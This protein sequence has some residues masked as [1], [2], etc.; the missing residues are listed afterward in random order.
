MRNA[1]LVVGSLLLLANCAPGSDVGGGGSGAGNSNGNGNGPNGSTGTGFGNGSTGAGVMQGCSPDL[2]SVIDASGNIIQT[3]P[4]DQ[5]CAGGTCVPACDAA[6]ASQGNVGCDFVVATPDFLPIIA[7]PCFAVFV[8]NNWD[9]DA[10]VSVSRAGSTF[11]VSAYGRIATNDPNVASWAPVPAT[12]IPPGKV[13]V[14]FLS[15]D[16]N[17]VNGTPLTCPIPPAIN[18]PGGSAVPGSGVGTSWHVTTDVP[19]STYDMLPYGGAA[20]FLPSAE[21]VQPT[22]AWGTNYVAVLP[23]PANFNQG[24]AGGPS[25]GQIVASQDGTTVSVLPSIGLPGAG[26]V[27]GAPA[28]QT[29]TFTLNAGDYVQWEGPEMTGSVFQSDKPISFTGGDGYICYQSQ[30]SSGGGCDSAHQ[31]IPAIR[32]LGSEYVAP[33]YHSRGT[34]VESIPYRLVGAVNGTVLAYDPPIPGAPTTL[35]LGQSVSFETSLPFKISSQDADHPFYVGQI[36]TGEGVPGNAGA[37]GDEEFVN[38]LPPAQWLQK[39]VFFTDPTYTTT[40]LVLVRLK[41]GDVFEDVNVDCVGPV[42]GW[43]PVGDG[44]KYEITDVDLV[45]DGTRNGA[46]ANGP[47][48][49]DSKGAFGLMVWGTAYY[50][51][52]AYPAGGNAASINTVVVPPVPQ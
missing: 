17:S 34:S 6:A 19:V 8:T 24:I 15:Q 52:Y 43:H 5:G 37:I 27:P 46:C 28:G 18:Q 40:N 41:H 12:G 49:A 3:C 11:D 2:K 14:I 51:S 9:K 32:A 38:I 36:M 23:M 16:P 20:S 13:G 33:P 35:A 48:T 50:A 25:W 10:T 47:H 7:P 39:Y 22:T 26:S 1:I 30:S 4:P 44:T 31:Q 29:T 42:A 21:L 45:R